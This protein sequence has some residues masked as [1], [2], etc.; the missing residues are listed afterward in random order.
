MYIV[1]S[2]D[3]QFTLCCLCFFP[4]VFTVRGESVLSGIEGWGKYGAHTLPIPILMR[5]FCVKSRDAG[6]DG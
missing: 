3:S 6:N 4:N 1:Y 5:E 2:L